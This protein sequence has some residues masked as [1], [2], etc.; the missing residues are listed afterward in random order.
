MTEQWPE[1]KPV[2]DGLYACGFGLYVFSTV[3]RVK[4]GRAYATSGPY[5]DASV[6]CETPIIRHYRIPEPAKPLELPRRFRAKYKGQD[7]VGCEY[8]CHTQPFFVT[9]PEKR[10]GGYHENELTHLTW[11]GDA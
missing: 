5:L 9:A 11:E 4:D 1:G 2:E 7:V 6:E 10:I 3:L 8:A